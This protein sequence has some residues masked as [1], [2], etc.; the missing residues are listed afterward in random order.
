M[1]KRDT[2]LTKSIGE[3]HVCAE[4]ARHGWAAALTRDGLA[5]TDILA[6]QADDD[7]R[8]TLVE[9]QVKTTVHVGD[10]FNWL[11]GLKAQMPAVSPREWFVLVASPTDLTAPVRSF[12]VPRDH[13]AAAAWIGHMT[14]LTDDKAAPGKRDTDVSQSRVSVEVFAGYEGRWDLLDAEHT[15]DAPVLLP[16]WMRDNA[17]LERVGLPAGHPWWERLPVW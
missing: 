1:P 14:W 9:I 2:K 15:N 7:E 8:R 3:H 11:L 10:K 4:L 17:Q 12:V 5:R 13:I 6:V 16:G